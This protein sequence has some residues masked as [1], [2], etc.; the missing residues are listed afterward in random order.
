MKKCIA[1]AFV[2]LA[3]AGPLDWITFANGE[4]I[5]APRTSAPEKTA[6]EVMKNVQV[7]KDAPASE[8]NSVMFFIAGSLGVGC[9][10]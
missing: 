9:E 2:I 4:Q 6:G 1:A 3:F 8:W 10:H 7:L 5:S